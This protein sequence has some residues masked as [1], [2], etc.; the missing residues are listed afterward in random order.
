MHRL[1]GEIRSP[2][3]RPPFTGEMLPLEGW[4]T[5][6][7]H[8]QLDGIGPSDRHPDLSRVRLSMPPAETG[9]IDG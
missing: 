7:L 9:G 2:A 6:D 4:L 1:S 8:C 3:S 5:V